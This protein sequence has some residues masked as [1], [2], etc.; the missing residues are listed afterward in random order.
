MLPWEPHTSLVAAISHQ[1]D[2]FN[3][4]W[5]S[6]N[7]SGEIYAATPSTNLMHHFIRKTSQLRVFS[8]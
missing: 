1:E 5:L 4:I 6:F 7:L 3:Q 8:Y 2:L